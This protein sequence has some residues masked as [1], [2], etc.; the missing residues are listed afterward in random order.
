MAQVTDDGPVRLLQRF[1]VVLAV[2]VVGFGDVE[3]D[4]APGMSGHHGGLAGQRLQEIE[5]EPARRILVA[6]HQRQSEILQREE[7]AALGVLELAHAVARSS[8]ARGRARC[9]SAGMT[10]RSRRACVAGAS[11]LHVE[12]VVRCAQRRNRGA[13][14]RASAAMVQ[15]PSPAGAMVPSVRAVGSYATSAPHDRHRWLSKK[16][17]WPQ[18]QA[19][20]FMSLSGAIAMVRR[21]VR[22][23]AEVPPPVAPGANATLDCN[24]VVL[25]DDLVARGRERRPN[26][27]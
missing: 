14:T 9:A 17:G 12:A 21:G 27:Q 23:R 18:V 8:V 20:A 25:G 5:R 15:S 10:G 1:A 2:V 22:A 3:R 26:P 11:Q 13:G 4:D 24:R 6:R 16:S 19:K 7:H